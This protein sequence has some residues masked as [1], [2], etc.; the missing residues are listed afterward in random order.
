MV[1]LI[2][3]LFTL[4]S[5]TLI[6]LT[7][8]DIAVLNIHL[9]DNLLANYSETGFSIYHYRSYIYSSGIFLKIRCHAITEFIH[10]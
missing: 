5:N 3:T 7:D 2:N 8:K 6:H 4:F 1:Y 9:K 10:F